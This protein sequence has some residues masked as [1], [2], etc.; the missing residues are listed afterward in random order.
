MPQTWKVVAE[1]HGNNPGF[2]D[3]A[4]AAVGRSEPENTGGMI[5]YVTDGATKREVSRVA[6]IR[7]STVCKNPGNSFEKQL[8]I[9]VD[10]A[11]AA[12]DQINTLFA[13]AGEM[14]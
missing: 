4:R 3:R 10:K 14:A 5:I 12:V 9:E 11:K 6:W 7:R 8:K 2:V 1:P 13:G